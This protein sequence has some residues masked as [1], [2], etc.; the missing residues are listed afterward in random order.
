MLRMFCYQ[1]IL[2]P[3]FIPFI[4]ASKYS[5]SLTSFLQLSHSV[6]KLKWMCWVP[7]IISWSL[8]WSAFVSVWQNTWYKQHKGGIVYFGLWFQSIIVGKEWHCPAAHIMAARKQREIGTGFPSLFYSVGHPTCGMLLPTFR[9]GLPPWKPSQT[10]QWVVY[11]SPRLLNSF[12][13]IIGLSITPNVLQMSLADSF[14][15]VH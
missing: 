13:L 15:A 7:N 12:K 10:P 9:A 14:S 5:N 3:L 1:A 11:S 6:R 8:C 2:Q 4:N